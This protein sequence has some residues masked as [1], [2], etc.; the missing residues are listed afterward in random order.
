VKMNWDDVDE[1]TLRLNLWLTQGLILAAAG[2]GSL[3]LHG[4]E[5]TVALFHFPKW[6]TLGWAGLV[7]AGVI[8]ASIAMD[9][10]LPKRWQDDGK[11]NEKMFGNMSTAGIFLVCAGVGA[12]E[13]WLFRGVLQTAAGNL[14]TSVI[15]TLL[16][17]R[18]LRKPLLIASLFAT[19]WLLGF[20]FDLERSLWAPIFAHIGIDLVLALYLRSSMKRTKEEVS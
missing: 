15:F 11:V 13:E 6:T 12:A 4:R 7:A 14:C 17:T 18:Y 8:A 16:H 5:G 3:W 1:K 2:I 20:L 19:S 9:R 10:F